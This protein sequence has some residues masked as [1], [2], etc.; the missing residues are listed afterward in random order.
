VFVRTYD[1]DDEFVRLVVQSDDDG[2]VDDFETAQEKG[3]VEH[4]QAE[5]GLAGVAQREGIA[6]RV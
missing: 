5:K 1:S 2:V 3:V 4:G 6:T